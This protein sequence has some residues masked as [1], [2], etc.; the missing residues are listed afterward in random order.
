M[1]SL[2]KRGY[3]TDFAVAAL[4]IVYVDENK[5]TNYNIIFIIHNTQETRIKLISNFKEI[6]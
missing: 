3:L 2:I 1:K 4:I 5:Y 6:K